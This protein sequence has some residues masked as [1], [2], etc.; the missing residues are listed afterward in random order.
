MPTGLA[1]PTAL[2]KLSLQTT[3]SASA[4]QT[5]SA[6]V[7]KVTEA[8][9]STESRRD[10]GLGKSNDWWT[11]PPKVYNRKEQVTN[12]HPLQD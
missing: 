4:S 8:L 12:I 7:S 5:T 3:S 1:K 2:T 10:S 9:A 6:K 11:N